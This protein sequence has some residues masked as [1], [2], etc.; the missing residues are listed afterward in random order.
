MGM[1]ITMNGHPTAAEIQQAKL[2]ADSPDYFRFNWSGMRAMLITMVAA[3]AV[4]DSDPPPK[5]P[6]WPPPDL[7]KDRK[8]LFEEALYD[9]KA[10]VKLTAAEK[11]RIRAIR[12]QFDKVRATRSTKK[13][14]VPAFKFTSNEGW[15]V[16][17]DECAVIA[18]KLRAF[19]TRA[20]Q[21]DLDTVDRAYRESQARLDAAIT[22]GSPDEVSLTPQGLGMSLPQYRAWILEWASYNQVAARHGGYHV[23]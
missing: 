15:I 3:D 16:A 9:E 6:T 1:D 20:T 7:P 5:F 4:S 19:A 11:T 10:E 17:S 13:G 8:E 22:K 21:K 14:K 18:T 2:D 12:Q 23:D